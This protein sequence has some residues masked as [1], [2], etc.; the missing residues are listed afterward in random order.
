MV[1]VC[2]DITF[3]STE[4]ADRDSIRQHERENAETILTF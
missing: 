3:Q 1:F 4:V 2:V